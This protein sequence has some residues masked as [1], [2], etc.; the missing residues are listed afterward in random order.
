MKA[1][2]KVKQ[3]A[4]FCDHQLLSSLQAGQGFS[5]IMVDTKRGQR[6]SEGQL[7]LPG[8]VWWGE[9]APSMEGWALL[10]AGVCWPSGCPLQPQVSLQA[11]V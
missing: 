3:W 7:F 2:I 8:V 9:L 4:L 11:P 6:L 5:L 10:C 1:E